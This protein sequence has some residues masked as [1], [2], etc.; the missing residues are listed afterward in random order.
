MVWGRF[1]AS[2]TEQPAETKNSILYQKLSQ[3]NVR[4]V[5]CNLELNESHRKDLGELNDI[6]N[7]TF[8]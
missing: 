7:V 2:G 6:E 1:A 3:E 4:S 8:L 5:T